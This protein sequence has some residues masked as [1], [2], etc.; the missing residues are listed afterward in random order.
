MVGVVRPPARKPSVW[1]TQIFVAYPYGFDSEGY[2][3]LLTRLE[4]EHS[5]RFRYAD[6]TPS[7]THL[8]EKVRE[9]IGSCAVSMFDLSG[10]N[11]NVAYEFEI[12]IGM[13]LPLSRAWLFLNTERSANV[14]SDIQGFAQN[15]YSDMIGLEHRLRTAL[16]G[17]P[18]RSDVTV[19]RPR[20][21]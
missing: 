7:A 9:R 20:D 2:R 11:A 5:I 18:K 3:D 21:R 10:W 17:Y 4:T 12:F 16:R 19:L 13:R 8:T 1:E 6:D 15:R 14:P